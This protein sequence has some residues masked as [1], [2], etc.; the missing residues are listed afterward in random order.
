MNDL[1][2]VFTKFIIK[3]GICYP[4]E[5]FFQ[6]KKVQCGSQ[7]QMCAFVLGSKVRHLMLIFDVRKL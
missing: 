2:N 1:Y 5:Y 4:A 6:Y 3:L 7:R